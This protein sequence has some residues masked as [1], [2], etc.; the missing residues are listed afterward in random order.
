MAD[1]V[2]LSL[3]KESP[4]V[5]EDG[6]CWFMSSKSKLLFDPDSFCLDPNRLRDAD[7]AQEAEVTDDRTGVVRFRPNDEGDLVFLVPLA[8]GVLS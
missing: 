5:G 6:V 4:N 7:A 8:W 1:D 3:L 2:E